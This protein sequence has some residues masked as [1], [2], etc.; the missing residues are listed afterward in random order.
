MVFISQCFGI[1]WGFDDASAARSAARKRGGGALETFT[2]TRGTFTAVQVSN[3]RARREVGQTARRGRIVSSCSAATSFELE[4]F[5]E[6]GAAFLNGDDLGRVG[7]L[8]GDFL[9]EEIDVQDFFD[10]EC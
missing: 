10:R 5:E 9:V 8:G 4:R 2:L 7:S 6:H 3:S 1:L